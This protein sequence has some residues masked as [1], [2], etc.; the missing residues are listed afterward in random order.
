M[1][2][3]SSLIGAPRS[4]L[5]EYCGQNRLRTTTAPPLPPVTESNQPQQLKTCFDAQILAYVD[6]LDAPGA[7][8]AQLV[9][10][11]HG[12]HDEESLACLDLLILPN[13]YLHNSARHRR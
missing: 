13:Q 12:F 5:S 4:M 10:H 3:T 9:L 8:S 7:W 2:P 1:P 11:L 6:L